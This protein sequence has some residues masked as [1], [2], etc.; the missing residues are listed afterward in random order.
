MLDNPTDRN[1]IS[2]SFPALNNDR[3][4]KIK[5]PVDGTY[6]CIA[7]A[8]IREDIWWWP[9]QQDFDGVEW[10]FSLPGNRHLTT[11]QEL[12]RNLKYE[13]CDSAQFEKGYQKIAIY[14]EIGNIERCTHAARQKNNGIW[15]SKLGPNWDIEHATPYSIEGNEYGQVACIMKRRFT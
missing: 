12:F 14:T 15:I 1:T 10:P 11:F 7:F 8:A 5:S 9:E 4:W 6:N 2:S 13:V 3:L